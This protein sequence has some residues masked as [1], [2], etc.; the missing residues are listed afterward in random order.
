MY[1][2]CFLGLRFAQKFSPVGQPGEAVTTSLAHITLA[3]WISVRVLFP[4]DQYWLSASG[5]QAK[6]MPW[7]EGYYIYLVGVVVVGPASAVLA[8]LLVILLTRFPTGSRAFCCVGKLPSTPP[9]QTQR[10]ADSGL[11]MDLLLSLCDGSVCIST[12]VHTRS[13]WRRR[14]TTC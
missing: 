5:E 12:Y 8:V 7:F 14:S 3:C 13:G 4:K 2:L 10:N 1:F 6:L 11:P 9:P